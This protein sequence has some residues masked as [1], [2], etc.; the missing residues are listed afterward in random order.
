LP[1]EF[2]GF[3]VG[4]SYILMN[5]LA[6]AT[7]VADWS[8]YVVDLINL[9]S[10][11]NVTRLIVEPPILYYPE[12]RDFVITGQV[13]DL[14]AIA[15]SCVTVIILLLGIRKSAIFNLVFVV[16]KVS[17]LLIFIFAGCVYVKRENY[18]PFFPPNEGRI[19]QFIIDKANLC[20]IY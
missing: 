16:F 3:F 17:V 19:R 15:I 5:Q 14:P 18:T 8:R 9:I 20:F 1:T 7:V 6:A 13:I 2:V 4:W 11:H 10:R 12:T